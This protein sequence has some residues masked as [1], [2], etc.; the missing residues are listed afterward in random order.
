MQLGELQDHIAEL[1]NLGA[2]VWAIDSTEPLE[3]VT[4]YAEVRNLGFPLLADAGLAVTKAYGVLNEA[5]RNMA[6]PATLVIDR[7]GVV[8][9]A[10]V[11]VDFTKRPPVSDLVAVLKK[12]SR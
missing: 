2:E 11:D 7:K 4:H 9:Y 1:R 5:S 6:Y 12:L 3:K 8:R 10:Q